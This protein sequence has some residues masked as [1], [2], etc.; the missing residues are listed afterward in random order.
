MT[1]A[2]ER[3]APRGGLG[4]FCLAG[5]IALWAWPA[6]AMPTVV[7]ANPAIVPVQAA[8]RGAPPRRMGPPSESDVQRSIDALHQRLR[9]TPAQEPAFRAVAEAMQEHAQDMRRLPRPPRTSRVSVVEGMRLELRYSE[10][11]VKG[12][13]RMVPALEA[14]YARLSPRQRRE[15][16]AFF[17]PRR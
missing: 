15:A 8:P 7:P 3:P 14:L 1:E 9:I 6:A 13:R 11:Q 2:T 17:R 12:L 16:D 5:A 4:A 10:A